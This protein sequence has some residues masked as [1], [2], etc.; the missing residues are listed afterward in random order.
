MVIRSLSCGIYDMYILI[1]GCDSSG[2][3]ASLLFVMEFLEI[4]YK[5]QDKICIKS[6]FEHPESA[7]Y[8]VSSPH[9]P[10]S[11]GFKNVHDPS[12]S[13]GFLRCLTLP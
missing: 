9:I 6:L 10:T 1:I 4:F 5:N 3:S 11:N 13:I 12:I 7:F 8:Y 2:V